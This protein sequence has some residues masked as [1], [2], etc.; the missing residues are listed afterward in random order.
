[1][2]ETPK[3]KYESHL[4][5]TVSQDGILSTEEVVVVP[6]WVH[7]KV[8]F[9]WKIRSLGLWTAQ[10]ILGLAEWI[11]D[12]ADGF[13]VRNTPPE[14]INDPNNRLGRKLGADNE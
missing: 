14:L 7:W 5:T 8:T 12:V 2:D 3:P 11:V 1:M 6:I 10:R 13:A 4:I 9:V